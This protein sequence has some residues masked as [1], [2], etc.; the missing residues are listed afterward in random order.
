MFV[1]AVWQRTVSTW[2]DNAPQDY[3]II[4][5]Y[6]INALVAHV[7]GKVFV[8]WMLSKT[9]VSPGDKTIG[10]EIFNRDR[11]SFVK[12]CCQCAAE[13]AG[14]AS[15]ELAILLI[16][17]YIFGPTNSLIYTLLAKFVM[18]FNFGLL[19]I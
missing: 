18:D 16:F 12:F 14:F 1:G 3:Q 9:K 10:S 13:N 8:F 17:G 2:I 4:Y 6:I 15:K 19:Y 7:G 5:F 11:D